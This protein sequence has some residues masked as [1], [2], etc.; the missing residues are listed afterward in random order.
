MLEND[1]SPAYDLIVKNDRL[2]MM[3]LIIELGGLHPL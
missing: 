1:F 3:E 2:Q